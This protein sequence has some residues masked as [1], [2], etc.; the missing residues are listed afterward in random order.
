[1]S[2]MVPDRLSVVSDGTRTPTKD[3][4]DDAG[5]EAARLNALD[6]VPVR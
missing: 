5:A 4:P 6:I 2:G 3:Q 1:M